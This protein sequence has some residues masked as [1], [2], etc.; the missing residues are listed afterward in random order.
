MNERIKKLRK[1]LDLTQQEFADKIGMKR[2][3]IANYETNRNEPSN[4]V[5]SL[6]CKTFNVSEEWLREGTGEMFNP[7]ASAA[8]EAL[9]RERSLTYSDYTIIEKFLNLKPQI[10]QIIAEFMIEIA[11]ALNNSEV[12][13]DHV[14]GTSLKDSDSEISKYAQDVKLFKDIQDFER[15]AQIFSTH[16]EQQD[17]QT[18]KDSTDEA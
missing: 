18:S 11:A 13:F 5:V 7:V 10:R 14:M 3:T 9:A 16:D 15:L 17:V 12:P 6:I 1:V 2:N 4:S 8:L